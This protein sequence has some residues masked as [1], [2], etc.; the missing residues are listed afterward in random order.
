LEEDQEFDLLH[1]WSVV[2]RRFW[3]LAVVVVVA[4]LV[5]GSVSYYL[6]PGIYSASTTL[7]VVRQE[8]PVLD[9]STMLMNT[10]LAKTYPEII[11]SRQIAK[12]VIGNL[13][14]PL[15][16]TEFAAKVKV[17]AVPNTLLI[18]IAVEDQNPAKAASI[19]NALASEFMR[20]VV[21][22]MKVENVSVVDP[23]IAPAEPVWPRPLLNMA[24]AGVLGAM[25]GLALVFMVE[26]LDNRLKTE[27]DVRR[28]LGLPVL[29]AIQRIDVRNAGKEPARIRP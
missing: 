24:V 26:S 9:Y 22:L 12:R 27:E 1:Y 15:T 13:G 29:G 10:Q 17:Q 2:K 3:V 25:I 5:A 21:D 8:T 6:L 14:L 23:A 11:R 18:Q 19:A 16:V 28:H 7:I 20:E 4:V